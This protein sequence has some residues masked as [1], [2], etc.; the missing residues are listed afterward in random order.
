M[1]KTK[2]YPF[3]IA[4]HDHELSATK[5]GTAYII[6]VDGQAEQTVKLGMLS[7]MADYITEIDGHTVAVRFSGGKVRISA[8][9]FYLDNNKPFFPL[10]SIPKW[11]YVFIVLNALIPIASLGGAIPVLIAFG[12]AS[13]CI[14]VSRT[15]LSI[16]AKVGV[17]FLITVA[18]WVLLFA[19]VIGLGMLTNRF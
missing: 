3:S 14:Y 17:S 12:G 10:S 15:K 13:A 7:G 5:N 8:D 1:A 4:G 18:A 9:G 2:S 6:S 19:V 11:T 16:P